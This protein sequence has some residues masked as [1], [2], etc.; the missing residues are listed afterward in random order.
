MIGLADY[1]IWHLGNLYNMA[2][3]KPVAIAETAF[4]AEDLTLEIFNGNTIQGNQDYQARY[5]DLLF[6]EMAGI[7]CRFI[8]WFAIRDYDQLWL[9]MEEQGVDGIFKSWRDT[10]LI[11]EEGNPRLAL[12]YWDKWL[13][14]P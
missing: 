10:G 5:L 14:I 13:S 9:S 11:D 6:S 12:E 2:P 4:L 1:T 7:D 3:G 8:T